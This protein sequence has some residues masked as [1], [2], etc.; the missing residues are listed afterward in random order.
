MA[1]ATLLSWINTE[2]DQALKLVRDNIAKFA[3]G[4]QDEAALAVCPEHLHQVSGALRMVG[5][6]GATRFCEALEGS[7]GGLKAVPATPEN[8]GVIDRAVFALREFVADLARGQADVPLRLWPAYRELGTLLGKADTSEKDLFFPDLLRDPPAHP[9]A[10]ALPEGEVTAFLQAQRS[11]FQ[12]GL[13]GWLRGTPAAGLDDMRQALD[14]L[15][16]VAQ[17]LPEPRAMWWVAGGLMDCL[18]DPAAK[19]LCNRIDFQIRDLAAGADKGS[20]PLLRELLYTLA[21]TATASPRIKEIRSHYQLESLFPDGGERAAGP[22]LDIEALEV[23][24]YDLHSRLD[25]L[26]SAWVQY[27]SG[28]PQA[29]ARVKDLA[30]AFKAKAA[31]LRNQHLT[32]MLDAIA[33]VAARLPDPYPAAQQYMIIEMASAFLLVENVI[34]HWSSPPE[35]LDQQ[36]VMMGGWLLDAAKGKSSGEPPKGLRADITQQIGVLQLRAHVAK[37]ISANLQNV[38]QV[39]DAFARDPAKRDTLA[40]LEPVLRQIHGALSVV[41][42]S[43]PAELMRVCQSLI[44]ECAKPDHAATAAD[45]DWIAEGLSSIGFFLDPCLHGRPPADEAVELFFERF[46]RTQPVP[47]DVTAKLTPAELQADAAQAAPQQPQK[48]STR[49]DIDA[50]LLEVFFEE[51]DEV[52]ASIEAAVP[53]CRKGGDRDALVTIRRGFHTLKGSGRMVGL[54]DL[55][56]VA[57]EIEQVMN[58]WLESMRPAGTD[59]LDLVSTASASFKRWLGELRSGSLTGEV[60][61]A[62]IIAFARCVKA[63]EAWSGPRLTAPEEPPPAEDPLEIT[64][65]GVTLPRSLFDIFM[66]EAGGHLAR[67]EAEFAGW[68]AAPPA[69]AS[70]E[71]MRAAHTLASS[72]RTAG[73]E[74]LAQPAGVLEQWVLLSRLTTDPADALVVQG[75]LEALRDTWDALSRGEQPKAYEAAAQDLLGLVERLQALP[76]EVIKPAEEAKPLAPEPEPQPALD[77]QLDFVPSQPEPVQAEPLEAE[78][79]VAAEPKPVEIR[80][81]KGKRESRVMRDDIDEQLL[82]I[83][84]EEAQELVP[85]IGSDLRDWKA[86][87]ADEKVLLSLQRALHTFKGSARMAG[88]I[89]LGELT[90]LMEGRIEQAL[91]AKSYPPELFADLEEKMD[92]LSLDIERMSAGQASLEEAAPAPQPEK[93]APVARTQK[94]RI[95]KPAVAPLAE[96]PLLPGTA[97]ML[98]VNADT[99]D[100]LINGAGEVAIARSR[101]EAELRGV[102]HTLG[103]LSESVA[104]MRSQL[105]EVEV[106]ADSQM[107]SRMSVVEERDREF[108]PLEFDRYTR[109]QE[110]TRLMA[111]SLNDI[112]S[113]QQGLMKNVGETD[114][115]L[116]QQARTNRDV[117]QELMRMRAVPFANLSERLYRIV[118][119][120]SRE[121]GKQ[122]ELEIEGA[123][124][125]LDRSVLERIG[126]PLEHMLRNAV[127]HGLEAPEVRAAAGK[128]ESGRIGVTLRQESNEIA[129]LVADDGAGL[130]LANLVK[131]GRE[132]GLVPEGYEPSEAEASQ[133]IF[134]S[135]LSTAE[136]V[137]QLSGRG[138]GMDVV[139][140]EI[141]AIGGRV[142][143]AT[144]RGQGTTFTIYLPLTLAV[145]Q[146]VLVRSGTRVLAMSS[147][148]VEQVL[149]LKGDA[150]AKLYA[151]GAVKFQERRYP[152]HALH[153]L[154][155]GVGSVEIHPSNAVLLLRSGVQ[156]IA[157]HVDELVGNQEIVVKSVGPQLARVPWVAGATVLPDGGIVLIANPVVL[158]QRSRAAHGALSVDA[159]QKLSPE[160]PLMVTPA[161]PEPEAAAQPTA[162]L[163]MV[164]DDSL[165]VRKIT[166]RLLE[167][168]GY[169]VLTAKDGVDALEQMQE[170]IPAVMLVDIE[171]PRMDG[172]DLT[173]NVRGD[174]RTKSVRIIIISSRT[175]EKHRT[176]AQQLGVDAFLGKPYEEGDLLRRIAGFMAA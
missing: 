155:G 74:A 142:D 73:F 149:R 10:Q 161:A 7:F 43:R 11:R 85:Q 51:A 153:A 84:L 67:L 171:M 57:W 39:L 58:G 176:Q 40:E 29:A 113:I 138:V 141:A 4:P 21:K 90:H 154:L 130:D 20:E 68:R 47:A 22:D 104:R 65:G 123:E 120:V 76:V 92:R 32:K 61:A 3:A 82:P 60:D 119:Q 168:E 111:E 12:R 98:R 157:L 23:A 164:V 174:A 101:V 69:D 46:E 49:S 117:Q 133:L 78:P 102:K 30:I 87:P 16:R 175:A 147:A 125:E 2:V 34:D 38:E 172:F 97:A 48:L 132:H 35:D 5:L 15:H 170:R 162:G 145:T 160:A 112:Y 72:S 8:I 137:T 80:K 118:R 159:T 106:Q 96:A 109:L 127:G 95:P 173:R 77:L 63:G 167:R 134:A 143:V 50:E 75:V 71:F 81:S 26:K 108:D 13:L 146:A 19:V 169:E 105:R 86:D 144:A 52:L 135:G 54:M 158:A 148:M 31:E 114:A 56:E 62:G 37:E 36:I 45:M 25:S 17:H 156:R 139:R 107:Q 91:D 9:Q 59:L 136:E 103:E 115:A 89:R 55:G 41:G 126:A 128:P 24:L 150:L 53:K 122:A 124:I 94:L 116:L 129:L 163:V 28:A 70:H 166:T 42:F 165:T 99:L 100:H 33:L 88:A 27:I 152:L 66:T 151:D 64:V 6:T 93:A 79:Q 18:D 121:L 140:S 1:N 131:K 14:A 110:L 83:F 44:A